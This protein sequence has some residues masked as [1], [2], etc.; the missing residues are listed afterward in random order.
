MASAA[1]EESKLA[2]A[3]QEKDVELGGLPSSASGL[4]LSGST[5]AKQPVQPPQG[6]GGEVALRWNIERMAVP[7]RKRMTGAAHLGGLAGGGFDAHAMLGEGG[8]GGSAGGGMGGGKA[9]RNILYQVVGQA[10]KGQML[11][12]MGAS[13]E[14]MSVGGWVD[15]VGVVVQEI[16]RSGCVR[17]CWLFG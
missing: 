4:S 16:K 11:A 13:G 7:V 6:G 10:E 5:A 14:C 3:P 15:V 17:F 1:L 9:E 2:L 8:G 12:L